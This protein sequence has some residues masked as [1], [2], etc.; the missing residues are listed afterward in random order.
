[1]SRPDL[2][3][4]VIY[5]HER[6]YLGPLLESLAASHDGVLARLILVDNASHDGVS[7]WSKLFTPTTIVCNDRRMT[8]AEN[9]NRILLNSTARYVLLL[10]TDM[11]FDPQ[12][13]CLS[14]MVRFLDGHPACGLAGCRLL[15]SDESEAYAARRF[16]SWRVALARRGGLGRWMQRTVG[17]YLYQERG[18][19]ETFP[20]DWLSGCF[21]ML[22][23]EA[24]RQVG[25]FD[26]AFYKYFEDVD[27]CLRIWQAGWDVMYYGGTHC[28]HLEQRASRRLISGDAWQ[29]ARSYVRWLRKWGTSP[30]VAR[31]SN[32]RR[33]A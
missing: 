17:E 6:Q 2:D 25:F 7:C 31:G 21:L 30:Q 11:Y 8:Y 22:R 9:L 19:R 1:M 12:V 32:M 20:C 16:Q 13:Q 24:W 10:N 26:T 14:A 15:H 27:Y 5:T 4:G 29:H 18:V 28:Y 23:R 3:I 33:A